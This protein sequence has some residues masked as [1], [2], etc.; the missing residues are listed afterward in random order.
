M[1]TFG[2]RNEIDGPPMLR[3]SE[4]IPSAGSI[5]RWTPAENKDLLDACAAFP[6]SAEM[7]LAFYN[8]NVDRQRTAAEVFFH[9][10]AIASASGAEVSAEFLSDMEDLARGRKRV[11]IEHRR[12]EE[13]SA[14]ED[15][16]PGFICNVEG[17]EVSTRKTRNGIRFYVRYKEPGGNRVHRAAPLGDDPDSFDSNRKAAEEF[18][19]RVGAEYK[20]ARSTRMDRTA[21]SEVPPTAKEA[22]EWPWWWVM[23][24]IRTSVGDGVM[25][26]Q[27][28]RLTV[29]RGTG[30]VK[31]NYLGPRSLSSI[32]GMKYCICKPP[33]AK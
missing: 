24:L 18:A 28:V 31:M 5:P 11:V 22:L 7:A 9:L 26:C 14:D 23:G 3:R 1:P 21:W 33:E 17:A 12:A 19:R 16:R 29:L 4:P 30:D 32:P 2:F 10:P 20:A 13:K 27:P 8:A 6:D 15:P 25:V